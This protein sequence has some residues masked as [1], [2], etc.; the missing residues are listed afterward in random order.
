MDWPLVFATVEVFF[1]AVL[2]ALELEVD[3]FGAIFFVAVVEAVEVVAFFFAVEAA[4]F[5]AV[6]FF[7]A[8]VFFF[9]VVFAAVLVEAA[10]VRVG[11]S[12]I[13][14]KAMSAA[15]I[16]FKLGDFNII[17]IRQIKNDL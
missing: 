3:F 7:F 15:V 6:T 11:T 17:L 1:A 5:F 4:G 12:P 9:V 10:K 2:A 13:V 16:N 8:V 14:L